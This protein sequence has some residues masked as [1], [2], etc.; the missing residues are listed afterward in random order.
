MNELTG[1]CSNRSSFTKACDWRNSGPRGLPSRALKSEPLGIRK[2]PLRLPGAVS[3][4]GLC[5]SGTVLPPGASSPQ[6]QIPLDVPHLRGPLV[7]LKGLNSVTPAAAKRPRGQAGQGLAAPFQ[8]KTSGWGLP[9]GGSGRDGVSCRQ[10]RAPHPALGLAACPISW[11]L[12]D[13]ALLPSPTT[14]PLRGGSLCDWS[15]RGGRTPGQFA[16]LDRG[17]S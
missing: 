10:P 14:E 2:A 9:P 7:V 12:P 4:M 15:G 3:P 11:T 6:R 16:G 13:P 1:P 17:G 5:L 8:I